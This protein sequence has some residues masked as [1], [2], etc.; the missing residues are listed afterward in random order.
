MIH[1]FGKARIRHADTGV[2]YEIDKD[3]LNFD[4][5][6]HT[7]K[8][9]LAERHKLKRSLAEPHKLRRGRKEIE[10]RATVDHEQ[11]GRLTWTI[12][13]VS[14]G[15]IDYQDYNIRNHKLLKS[16]DFILGDEKDAEEERQERIGKLIEWFNKNYR[17]LANNIFYDSEEEGSNPW[18][19]EPYDARDALEEQFP[20]ENEDI[21]Y[22]AVE[23]I[24][25]ISGELDWS[26]IHTPEDASRAD[27][28]PDYNL[29]KIEDDLNT[30]IDT[31]PEPTT[32]P[33]FAFDKD[34]LLYITD[35]P[36]N[37]PVDSQDE[38]LDE[39]RMIIDDLSKLFAG[40][41][42]YSNFTPIIE[43]YKEAISGDQISITRL[44]A[45]GIRLKGI[46]K[47]INRDIESGEPSLS[48]NTEE[49]LT[50][51]ITLHE[52]YI[53][54]NP[55]GQRLVDAPVAHNRTPEQKQELK[56]AGEQIANNV[57]KNPGLFDVDVRGLFNDFL[58]DIANGQYSDRLA[59]IFGNT[60]SNVV[61]GVITGFGIDAIMSIIQKGIIDSIPA[62]MAST[63]VTGF[64][65]KG[66]GFVT[67]N[68][69]QIKAFA[70]SFPA[71]LPWLAEAV[72]ILERI[73]SI[74]G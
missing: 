34:N 4:A 38:L 18:E 17:D 37:Q 65:D 32:D 49:C 50:S 41:N 47:A 11:L 26:L 51:A 5:E 33:A 44:Y 39:L 16:F 66:W 62:K 52:T 55:E 10:Y 40:H 8:R 60:V 46:A 74:I 1:A 61:L 25:S 53:M 31:A 48:P 30:L 43:S 70:N 15:T 36:D 67:N 9:S 13:E 14:F 19:D 71:Q 22:A 58:K 63:A 20:N 28:F 54:L 35:P 45:R 24:A 7:R 59:Q 6:R 42:I 23:V 29:K 64:I 3:S 73:A 68:L 69:V 56:T 21:I 57:T 2:V 27:L 12:W 72:Q